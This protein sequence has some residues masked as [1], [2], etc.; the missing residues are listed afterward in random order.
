MRKG[1]KILGKLVSTIVLLLIFLPIVITLVLNVES[2]QNAVVRQASHYA[3]AYLGTDV[4]VDGIDFDLFSKV[5]VRG[6]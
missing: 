2:V 5:R 3:S 1:I 4:Y 6:L